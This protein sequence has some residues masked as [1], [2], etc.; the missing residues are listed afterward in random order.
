MSSVQTSVKRFI[1]QFLIASLILLCLNLILAGLYF[2]YLLTAGMNKVS[3]LG[4]LDQLSHSLVLKE[5]RYI[6]KPIIERQ[7]QGQPVWVILLNNQ[8]G[9]ILW[10]LNRPSDIPDHYDLGDVAAL[11]RDYLNGYPVFTGNHPNGLLVAGLAKDSCYRLSGVVPSQI[12]LHIFIFILWNVVVLFGLYFLMD[13]RAL[14]SVGLLLQGIRSISEGQ[15]VR[16]NET[17]NFREIAQG[18]NRTSDILKRRSEAREKW[19]AGISHDV[20]TPLSMMIGY[21]DRI[22]LNETISQ[23]VRRQAGIILSQGL[24]LRE[25]VNDLNLLSWI[26]NGNLPV[27]GDNS[28]VRPTLLFRQIAT[29]FLNSEPGCLF[30]MD[31]ESDDSLENLTIGGDPHLLQRAINNLLYNCVRHNPGGCTISFGLKHKND[32]CIFIV[33]DNG[34]G[35]HSRKVEDERLR[36]GEHGL[37]LHIVRQIVTLFDGTVSFSTAIPNGFKAII[38]L[39]LN[40]F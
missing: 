39:P 19:I 17:G 14:K 29:D 16:L 8:K 4:L 31:I 2:A 37:G 34:C 11:S 10:S 15:T 20:R 3:P 30:S 28:R 38:S 5:G 27:M 7:V 25:L 24:Q 18:I 32:K 21:A 40:R 1:R 26:E 22:G 13:R 12:G 35:I 33:S 36:S 6:L 9:N 23:D